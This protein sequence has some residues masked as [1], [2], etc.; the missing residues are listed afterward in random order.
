MFASKKP[1]TPYM[2]YLW[3]GLEGSRHF[4]FHTVANILQSPIK[5]P[6]QCRTTI[7]WKGF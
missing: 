6:L 7:F 5:D 4:A 3:F 1:S 2:A